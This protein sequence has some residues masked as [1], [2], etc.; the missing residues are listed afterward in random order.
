MISQL[1]HTLFPGLNE[2]KIRMES[3]RVGRWLNVG[4]AEGQ[5]LVKKEGKLM[6]EGESGGVRTDKKGETLG[7]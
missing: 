6:T 1:L 4:V 7:S 2:K 3:G 5:K